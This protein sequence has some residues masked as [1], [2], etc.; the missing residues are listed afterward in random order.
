MYDYISF[1]DLNIIRRFVV[2]NSE[3]GFGTW[4]YYPGLD[5]AFIELSDF[6]SSEQMLREVYRIWDVLFRDVLIN[7]QRRSSVSQRQRAVQDLHNIVETFRILTEEFNIQPFHS[8]LEQAIWNH[9]L[10]LQTVSE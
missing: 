5:E 8:L 9:H 3:Y 7:N 1:R 2:A 10:R 6:T 4:G